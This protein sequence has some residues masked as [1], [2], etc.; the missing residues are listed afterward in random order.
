MTLS[1]NWVAIAGAG[2]GLVLASLLDV[3]LVVAFAEIIS[4]RTDV[5][6]GFAY[7]GIVTGGN[8]F[9]FDDAVVLIAV[10]VAGGRVDV[11]T[12]VVG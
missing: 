1:D 8:G 5:A 6:A 4:V 7:C 10:F 2:W 3:S 11:P 12:P 9:E